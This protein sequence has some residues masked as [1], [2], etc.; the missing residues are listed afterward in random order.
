MIQNDQTLI[1]VGKYYISYNYFR[2]EYNITDHSIT[3][4]NI[5]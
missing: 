3:F 5:L 1:F 2:N 4:D